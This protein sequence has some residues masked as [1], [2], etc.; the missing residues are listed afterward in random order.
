MLGPHSNTHLHTIQSMDHA[1]AAL[2]TSQQQYRGTVLQGGTSGSAMFTEPHNIFFNLQ[3]I[4]LRHLSTMTIHHD[5]GNVIVRYVTNFLTV[6][7]IKS[8]SHV[9]EYV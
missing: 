6:F 3:I 1:Q 9:C 7:V 4:A 2:M 8:T 5:G